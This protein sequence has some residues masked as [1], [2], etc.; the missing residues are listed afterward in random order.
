MLVTEVYI[1]GSAHATHEQHVRPRDVELVEHA[2][3][4]NIFLIDAFVAADAVALTHLRGL[5]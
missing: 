4:V 1:T 5:Y 3:V 2:L